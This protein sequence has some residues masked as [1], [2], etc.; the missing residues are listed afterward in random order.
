MIVM[1]SDGIIHGIEEIEGRHKTSAVT[2]RDVGSGELLLKN[3]LE[4][5]RSGSPQEIEDRVLAYAGGGGEN[6]K[7]DMTVLVCGIYRNLK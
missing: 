6:Q 1:V 5:I 7:D 4:K 2:E 3:Y